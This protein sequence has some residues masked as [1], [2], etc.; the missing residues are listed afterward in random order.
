[1]QAKRDVKRWEES[2]F[3]MEEQLELLEGS[4]D[5]TEKSINRVKCRISELEENIGEAK[6]FVL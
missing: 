1:M 3:A 6:N 5:A 4:N 2:A